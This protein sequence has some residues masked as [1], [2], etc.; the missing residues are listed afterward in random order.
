MLI[1]PTTESIPDII[2]INNSVSAEG[3]TIYP[4][5]ILMNIINPITN[6]KN[7]LNITTGV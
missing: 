4:I 7:D 5:T 3:S 6:S 2:A 1:N